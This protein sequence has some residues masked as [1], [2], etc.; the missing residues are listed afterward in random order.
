MNGAVYCSANQMMVSH[1][2]SW[3]SGA[4]VVLQKFVVR[5]ARPYSA[6]LWAANSFRSELPVRNSSTDYAL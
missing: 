4:L 1:S 2:G 3:H 6:I 5:S